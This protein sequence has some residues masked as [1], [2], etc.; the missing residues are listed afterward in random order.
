[1]GTSQ[2]GRQGSGN[3]PRRLGDLAGAVAGQVGD[4][5]LAQRNTTRKPQPLQGRPTRHATAEE[6][7]EKAA[8][9]LPHSPSGKSAAG[10]AP[11]QSCPRCGGAGWVKVAEIGPETNQRTVMEPCGCQE[12]HNARA[13]W[14]RALAASDMSPLL[15]SLDFAGYD[16]TYNPDVLRI[17]ADWT[18]GLV[19]AREGHLPMPSPWVL[20]YGGMG[21][22]KTHLLAAAFNV[23]LGAGCYPLYTVV[24]ALLDHI[25]EGLDEPDSREYGARFRAVRSTE[26]LLLDDLGAER[27]SDWSDE[28]L[29]KLLDHRYREG[30]PTLVATNLIPGDLE[31]RIASRLQD[32]RLS[33]VLLMRGP[34]FRLTDDLADGEKSGQKGATR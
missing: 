4:L 34:D 29:F 21:T 1:M 19:C 15:R 6:L 16:A 9:L 28:L 17:V 2:Q 33:T 5:R 13:R 12:A 22:G 26:I 11:P 8:R 30:L 18:K 10:S 23:L 7:R 24:P 3:T 27:S 32:R 14:E 25:R 31:P 20:L